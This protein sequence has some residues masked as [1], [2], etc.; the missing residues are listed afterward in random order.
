MKRRTF[1]KAGLATGAT[2]VAVSA[3]ILAPN[4]VLAAKP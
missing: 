4:T 3:G 1:L 2:A